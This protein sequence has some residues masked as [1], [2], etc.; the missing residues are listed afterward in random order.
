MYRPVKS[1]DMTSLQAGPC[2][3]AGTGHCLAGRE[4]CFQR[5][6]RLAGHAGEGLRPK[7]MHGK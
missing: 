4:N 1:V 6:N 3:I 5:F 7:Y 2:H